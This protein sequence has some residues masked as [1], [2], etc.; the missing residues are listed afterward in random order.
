LLESLLLIVL[1][2]FALLFFISSKD[3]NPT[4]ALFP[5]LVSAAALLLLACDLF[6][7]GV[8]SGKP[9]VAKEEPETH[10]QSSAWLPAMGLQ[11]G[12]LIFIYLIGFIPATFLF[13]LAAPWQMRYRRRP[14]IALHAI[15]LTL[16]IFA[17]FQWLFNVRLPKGF[18]GF[19]W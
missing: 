19:P 16:A 10:P 7:G 17:S 9:P 5:R 6:L 14:I 1:G 4:A 18:V 12:Y 13:L 11:T 15:L 3:S 2:G 8:K